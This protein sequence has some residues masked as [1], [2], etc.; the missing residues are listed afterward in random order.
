[1]DC[2]I[3]VGADYIVSNDGHFK[4]LIDIPFPSVNVIKAEDFLLVLA[5][6]S[7]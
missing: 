1:V 6:M 2:A 7:S 5:E 4:V 3:A